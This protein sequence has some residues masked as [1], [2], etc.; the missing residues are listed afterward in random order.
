[1]A[2]LFLSTR[3]PSFFCLVAL[4]PVLPVLPAPVG[5]LVAVVVVMVLSVLVGGMLPVATAAAE[6]RAAAAAMGVVVEGPRED[7]R[8]GMAVLVVGVTPVECGSACE[9][10]GGG[11]G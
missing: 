7:Y 8:S 6:L 10:D 3:S 1:M 11:G 5:A 4:L 2:R 9:G